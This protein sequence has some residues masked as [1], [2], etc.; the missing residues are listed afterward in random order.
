MQVQLSGNSRGI[1]ENGLPFSLNFTITARVRGVFT[2]TALED[3]LL[4]LRQ[5]HPLLA[6]R[7]EADAAGNVYFTTEN[8]PAIPL[9]IVNRVDDDH[10][11]QE[12]ERELPIGYD[13]RVGPL[14][15]CV[16]LRGA[17]VSDL[18]L[19]CDHLSADG[20]ACVYAMRDLLTLLA[21]PEQPLETEAPTHLGKLIPESV[22][23]Y[24]K[25]IIAEAIQN[26]ASMEQPHFDLVN[27][28]PPLRV[29]PFSLSAEETAALVARA[30]A[31]NA[32]VQAAL[33]AAFL[34]PFAEQDPGN[35]TRT[36]ET[37]MDIRHRLSEPIGDVYG[38]Y[39]SLLFTSVDCSPGRNLWDIARDVTRDLTDTE[40]KRLFSIPL[41]LM[42]VAEEPLPMPAVRIN[43][44]ISISNLG[45]LSLPAQYGN[46]ILEAV[47]APSFNASRPGHHVLG[48][49]TYNGQLRATFI[50]CNPAAPALLERSRQLLAAM[51]Q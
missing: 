26:A 23:P 2:Q 6:S 19:V 20:R 40:E 50:S 42:T 41:I 49:N 21:H 13:H 33:C 16:W 14:L 35:P 37:P 1:A 5:R 10:W 39:I 18:I 43:Y 3:A 29:L 31:E 25:Q 30:R 9:R 45:R 32:T 8:V 48:V 15:R 46:L 17:E 47:Y 11:V 51:I 12:V 24:I 36:V 44:D 22:L 34:T 7:V 28:I 4:K 27:D 38:N